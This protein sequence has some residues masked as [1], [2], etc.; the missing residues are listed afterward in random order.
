MEIVLGVVLNIT[1]RHG[2][3]TS[4][5]FPLPFQHSL[6]SS[7]VPKSRRLQMRHRMNCQLVT[8]VNVIIASLNALALGGNLSD[9]IASSS[10]FSLL[11]SVQSNIIRSVFIRV[12]SFVVNVRR[13]GQWAVLQHVFF[14]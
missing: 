8:I 7:F 9:P 5:V 3:S 12:R 1:R 11:S 4:R 13:R 10:C 14:L 6:F 2:G